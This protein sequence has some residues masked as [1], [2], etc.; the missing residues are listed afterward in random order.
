MGSISGQV[1]NRIRVL[2][3]D[4]SRMHTQLLSEALEGDPGLDVVRW[5]WNPSNLIS[6]ILAHSI[7]VLVISSVLNGQA[8]HGFEVVRELR[9]ASPATKAV[10]LLDSPKDEVVINA[11]RA[12]ARG[13]F[14]KESSLEI[15]RKCVHRIHQGEIWADNRGV[16]LAV[17][18][19]A[20]TP[21]VRAVSANGLNLLSKRELEVVQCVVQGLTNREIADRMGLSQHTIKNYL[22]RIFDKLGVSSRVELLFMTLSLNNNPEQSWL[23]E[24]T[25]KALE[26]DQDDETT[27]SILQRAAEKGSPEAQV[28]LAQAYLA[29]RAQPADL[30]HAYM[31]YLI[32]SER[33]SQARSLVTEMLTPQ[34]MNEAQQRARAWLGQLKPTSVHI[35]KPVA[36]LV[37]IRQ[38]I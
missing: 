30:V 16:S 5:D 3:A 28:A 19:L 10:V 29:R 38:A 17:D 13:I 4:N 34:E 6:T 18:A 26:G 21:V 27:V 11:F 23:P 7:D 1:A 36:R 33:V 14:S 24:A 20:S 22:F 9:A 37:P 2:V 25:T 8:G 31:W 15:F 32:A 12:G 35:A